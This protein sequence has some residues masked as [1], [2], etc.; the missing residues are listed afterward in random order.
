MVPDTSPPIRQ[1]AFDAVYHSHFNAFYK[2]AL[3]FLHHD[4][5]AKG[6]VQDAF[7]KLWE[8]GVNLHSEAEVKNYL[9]IVVR[10]KCL[11]LLRDRKKKYPGEADAGNLLAA[12]NY[13]LLTETGED[14]LLFRELSEKIQ[15]SVANL[16]PQCREVFR[17]SRFDDLPNKEIAQKLDIS[18]KAVE[19]N[20]TRAL[21][22]L[23]EELSPY[24]Q[25]EDLPGRYM[26]IRSVLI[27]F[28]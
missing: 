1:K 12:I 2:I 23:R 11:N 5:D 27:S 3:H 14:V 16:S 21:K 4:E 15:A 9:F 18:V 13:R 26:Q 8:Q 19:A 22:S 6:V 10:N 20:I 28:L 17:M 25:G 7:I 24:L